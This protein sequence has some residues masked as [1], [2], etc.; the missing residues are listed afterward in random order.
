[1]T[2][3]HDQRS[4]FFSRDSGAACRDILPTCHH[5]VAAP[6]RPPS[7]ARQSITN[8]RLTFEPA[9]PPPFERRRT[10]ITII[11]RRAAQARVTTRYGSRRFYRAPL[12]PTMRPLY[13]RH[14][15]S[16]PRQQRYIR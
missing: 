1:V 9:V 16:P 15:T 4:A 6:A 5:V 7:S 3:S 12:L 14:A 10:A 8:I 13:Y 2:I 11:R